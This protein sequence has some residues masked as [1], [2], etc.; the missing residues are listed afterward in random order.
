MS[1]NKN[2][3]PFHKSIHFWGQLTIAIALLCTLTIPLY[4]T[5]VLGYRPNSSDIISGLISIAGFVGIVWF[6]E[7]ISYFPTLGPAGTYMSFLSGNIGNMRLPVIVGTQDA[8]GLTPGSEEAEV[9]GIFALISSTFT[10]LAVL[11]VVL[12]AGQVIVNVLPSAILSSFNFA[13]PGILGAMLVMM[14]SKIKVPNLVAL[15]AIGVASM[16]FIR[17]VPKFLPASIATPISLADTGIIA[18][19]GI[20][21]SILSAKK[22]HTTESAAKA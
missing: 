14:G 15:V 17:F 2:V 5:F 21:Y 6:I 9:A 16:V 8:L 22:D 3:N 7:P 4:L 12:V 11:A 20:L 1:N 19:L 18:V 10:N 13:L